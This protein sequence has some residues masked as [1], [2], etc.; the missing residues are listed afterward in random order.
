MTLRVLDALDQRHVR[1]GYVNCVV[2]MAGRHLDTRQ[3][4]RRRFDAFV[5]RPI[6]PGGPE[7]REFERHI[8]PDRLQQIRNGKEPGRSEKDPAAALRRTR[9]GGHRYAGH[10]WLAQ[11]CLPSHLGPLAP[12]RSEVFLEHTRHLGFLAPT[13][14]LTEAGHVLQQLLLQHAPTLREGRA[15]PNPL[16]VACRVAV[17]GLYLRALLEND[18][19]MPFLLREIA[20]KPDDEAILL[21]RAVDALLRAFVRG[22]RIDD[23]MEIRKLRAYRDRVGREAERRNTKVSCARGGPRIPGNRIHIHHLRPRLEHYVDIGLLRRRATTNDSTIGYETVP[24][25]A[26]A[27]AAWEPILE[28]PRAL[29][30]FLDEKFFVTAAAIL[31]I[32]S[33]PCPE[34]LTLGYLLEAFNLIGR[35]IGF[36]PARTLSLMAGLL[37]LEK[38]RVVEIAQS[39]DVVRTAAG[40]PLGRHLVFSGGSRLDGEFLVRIKPEL[41]QALASLSTVGPKSDAPN[42]G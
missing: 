2:L 1:L 41:G 9:L 23:A 17:Q 35:E 40:S 42:T 6:S 34:H 13:Y 14:S 21:P 11:D 10:L 36:T 32:P 16:L 39:F 19:L 5:F 20:V 18:L 37:A 3:E 24:A 22:A 26:R 38:G 15:V 28:N 30:R 25:T 31:G 7:M 29:T 12:D 8:A 4:L 27:I 33:G